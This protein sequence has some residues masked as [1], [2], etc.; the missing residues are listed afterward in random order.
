MASMK[1]TWS[2]VNLGVITIKSRC[3]LFWMKPGAIYQYITF[4]LRPRC[5]AHHIT[6]L[7]IHQFEEHPARSQREMTEIQPVQIAPFLSESTP[8]RDSPPELIR[9][10]FQHRPVSSQRHSLSVRPFP[11]MLSYVRLPISRLQLCAS[12][13]NKHTV[14]SP[15]QITCHCPPCPVTDLALSRAYSNGRVS[16]WSISI[17]APYTNAKRCG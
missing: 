10:H 4:N 5:N 9:W 12:N 14:N 2:E 6:I 13:G 15:N 3:F 7:A 17:P 16:L 11:F 8:L 1:T